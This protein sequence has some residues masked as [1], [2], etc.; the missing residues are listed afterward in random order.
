MGNWLVIYDVTNNRRLAK[1]ARIIEGY[2]IRVQKS[3]FEIISNKKVIEGLQRKVRDIMKE[4]DS[5][6]YLIQCR[7]SFQK[8][9]RYGLGKY[10]DTKEKRFE[11]L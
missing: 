8:V 5:V 3:V 6:I 7:I 11:I 10:I 9:V 2:G 1:I 4:E